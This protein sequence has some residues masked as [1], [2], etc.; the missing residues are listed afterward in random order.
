MSD[1]IA[2]PMKSGPDTGA[3][4]QNTRIERVVWIP[5]YT[6]MTKKTMDS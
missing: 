5:A 3:R 1:F 2:I 6:G 4:I